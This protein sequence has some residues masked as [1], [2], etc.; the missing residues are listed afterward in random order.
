MGKWNERGISV[1]IIYLVVKIIMEKRY[2]PLRAED[3][4]KKRMWKKEMEL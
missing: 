4:V 1:Y 2:E 3:K